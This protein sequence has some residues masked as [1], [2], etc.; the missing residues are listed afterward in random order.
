MIRTFQD[1]L[2]SPPRAT[3]E[4]KLLLRG[5]CTTEDMK[6]LADGLQEAYDGFK[7]S[8]ILLGSKYNNRK[9]LACGEYHSCGNL[10]CPNWTFE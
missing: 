6:Q 7:Q 9:C 4:L 2:N 10:P 3:D 8:D 1:I 5:E